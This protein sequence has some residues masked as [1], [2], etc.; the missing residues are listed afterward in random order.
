V[1]AD[2]PAAGSLHLRLLTEQRRLR[3]HELGLREL[4]ADAGYA[5]RL[6]YACSK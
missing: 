1:Q 4:L 6:E 5:N 3:S 2:L